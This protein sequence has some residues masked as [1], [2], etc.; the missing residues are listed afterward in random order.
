M[1]AHMTHPTPDWLNPQRPNSSTEYQLMVDIGFGFI[2]FGEPSSVDKVLAQGIHELDGKKI[3]PKVAF[4]RRAH[5]KC[6]Q[7]I[8]KTAV[9]T[10]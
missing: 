6:I 4:P 3:D 10:I 8:L 2:T 9:I 7:K 1:A 5:P